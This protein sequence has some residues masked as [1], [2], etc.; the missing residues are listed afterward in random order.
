MENMLRE[1]DRA[2]TVPGISNYSNGC[3]QLQD[4]MIYHNVASYPVSR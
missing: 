4:I 3:L 1:L 2:V